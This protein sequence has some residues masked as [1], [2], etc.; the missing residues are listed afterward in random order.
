MQNSEKKIYLREIKVK[1]ISK[2]IDK[3]DMDNLNTENKPRTQGSN[4]VHL[5]FVTFRT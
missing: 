3:R 4:L 1:Y 2:Q 5:V